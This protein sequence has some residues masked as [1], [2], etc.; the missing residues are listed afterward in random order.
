MPLWCYTLIYTSVNYFII[1]KK[2]K[3]IIA[4]LIIT[5]IYEQRNLLDVFERLYFLLLRRYLM[6]LGTALVFT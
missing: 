3:L 5:F 6:L 4:K 1:I 2:Y